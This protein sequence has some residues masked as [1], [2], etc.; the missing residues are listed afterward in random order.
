MGGRRDSSVGAVTGDDVMTEPVV[1]VDPVQGPTRTI[2]QFGG[3][4]GWWCPIELRFVDLDH[5]DEACDHLPMPTLMV[6]AILRDANESTH[7]HSGPYASFSLG[8]GC[9]RETLLSRFV[10]IRPNPVSYNSIQWGKAVHKYLEEINNGGWWHEFPI[11]TDGA[12]ALRQTETPPFE[13]KEP[14]AMFGLPLYATIDRVRKDFAALEDY[15]CQGDRAY[16]YHIN[17]APGIIKAEHAAQLNVYRMALEKALPEH[18]RSEQMKMSAWYG[19]MTASGMAPWDK[20]ESPYMTEDDITVIK[21]GGGKYTFGQNLTIIGAAFKEVTKLMETKEFRALDFMQRRLKMRTT[22]V[23]LLKQLP[24]FGADMF[25][26]KKCEKYCSAPHDCAEVGYYAGGTKHYPPI[27]RYKNAAK[28][29][30]GS[31]LEQQMAG[32]KP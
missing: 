10:G 30:T 22:V 9:P 18:T 5:F 1:F 20:C 7:Y 16:S 11:P 27:G 6:D 25:G 19:C 3:I 4:I 31:W 26:G 15:K 32:R 23:D 14:V 2:P 24:F 21:P 12:W 28:V 8:N 29:K 13:I 17:K